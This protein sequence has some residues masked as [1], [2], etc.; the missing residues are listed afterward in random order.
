MS[1]DPKLIAG[2][3]FCLSVLLVVRKRATSSG[4][5]LPP[6]P[7]RDS[8]LGNTWPAAFGYRKFEEW[9]QEYGPLFTMR[10]GFTTIIVIGRLQAATDIM[11]KEGVSLID[12]PRSIAAGETLSGGMRLLMI[13]A[14]ERFKKLR[15]ALHAHLQPKS[16]ASYSMTLQKIAR[17]FILDNVKDP[18]K[19]QEHARKYAASV[20]MAL[21]YGKIPESFQDP[22]VQAVNE[23]L[24]RLGL[25]MRPGAWLV[26]NIPILRYVPGY[27]KELKDGHTQEL[28]LFEG[29][30]QEVRE[31]LARNEEVPSCF[32]RYVIEKQ[33]E[34]ELDDAE[35]AYLAGSFFGAGSDTTAS[36]ISVA[37]MAATCFPDTQ[38]VVQDELD[39]IVGQARPPAFADQDNLPQ[40]MAFIYESFRWRPVTSG[41][42]PHK[43]T[44]DIIWQNYCIP[45]GATVIGN[46]WSVG[47]DPAYFPEPE[48]FDPQRWLTSDGKLRED[49][50]SYPFGF[51]RRV[52]PGQ[53][54]ATASTFINTALIL[55]AFNLSED[56]KSPIDTLAF[57]ESAN[58]HPMPFQPIFKPRLPGGLD[59][60]KEGME[61][62][63]M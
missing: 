11:E 58:A 4:Y 21:A 57:T 47:R 55:W 49:L 17:T 29:Q 12:R 61:E 3:V 34:L 43:A 62:Y 7:P 53:Y 30:M 52:C 56:P 20:V 36:A 15:R 8:I 59:A 23:C 39:A 60:V 38:K 2:L 27:L 6:G 42:F 24:T 1:L 19:H 16:I 37:I 28:N 48:K 25:T 45:K 14:G 50:K 44:K 51:G 54:M 13:P 46:V 32:G 10:Q 9:T 33:A 63:G 31:K 40:T 18:K 5:P 22:V 26:D 35:A 41:G